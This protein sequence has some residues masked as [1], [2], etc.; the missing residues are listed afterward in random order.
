MPRLAAGHLRADR[1]IGG[2]RA[3]LLRARP[4]QGVAT[5]LFVV[6]KVRVDRSVE[7]RIVELDREVVALFR[8][9]LGPGGTDFG[10][11]RCTA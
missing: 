2:S 8:G 11:M 3:S 10:V 6:E 9:A 4:D 1:L 7:A 5:A